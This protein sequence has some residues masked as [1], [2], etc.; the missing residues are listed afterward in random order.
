MWQY[1]TNKGNY[2]TSLIIK[3][4][5]NSNPQFQKRKNNIKER[6]ILANINT[7]PA[8]ERVTTFGGRTVTTAEYSDEFELIMKSELTQLIGIPPM[9]KVEKWNENDP[10]LIKKKKLYLEAIK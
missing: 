6:T 5:F 8:Q 3:L 2:S 9:L 10:K 7:Q 1:I 4:F